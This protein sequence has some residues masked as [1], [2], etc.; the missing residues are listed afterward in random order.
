MKITKEQILKMERKIRREIELENNL[1]PRPCVHKSKKTYTRKRK[2]K[3][4]Q[5]I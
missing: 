1:R 2:H 3:S 5:I 4:N